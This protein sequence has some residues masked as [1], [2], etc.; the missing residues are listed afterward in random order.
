MVFEIKLI[1]IFFKFLLNLILNKIMFWNKFIKK[2]KLF[3]VDVGIINY[4][5]V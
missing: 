1:V 5:W 2:V 4:K 3:I